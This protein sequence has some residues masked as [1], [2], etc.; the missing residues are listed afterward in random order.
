MTTSPP[1][2]TPTPTPTP[3]PPTRPTPLSA[4]RGPLVRFR[5][6]PFRTG[7]AEALVH[8]PDGLLICE[9]GRITAAGPYAALRDRLPPGTEPVHYP[10]HLITA[11]FVDAH[12]H[13][14]QL[15]A[16]A[17]FGAQLPDWLGHTYDT[18]KRFAD[19]THARRVA[20]AFCDELLRN[21]TTTALAF[22]SVHPGSA[23]A[24]F[25][26]AT[27]RDLRIAA[28]K[29]LMDRNA[30]DSLLDTAQRAYDESLDLIQ[31]WHGKGRNLYAV[32]PR[33]APTS[34]P[35]Q[36]EAARALRAARPDTLL[37]THISEHR[38]EIPWVRSLFPDRDGYLDV[39]D[40]YGLLGPRT[41]LA[42]GIHLTPSERDHCARTGTAVAHCPSSNL[43]LGSGLFPL[44]EAKEGDHPLTVALGTDIGAGTSFSLLQTM[45]DAHQVAKLRDHALDAVRAFYLATRGGA[46][47]LGLADTI[48]SLTPG[49]EADFAVLDPR[50]T[51]L[52]AD[53][54]AR[55]ETIEDLLFALA[56]LG[57]DRAVRATYTGGR[58]AHERDAAT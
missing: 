21:G 18:E 6:D 19:G 55:A 26:E 34:T 40:H 39:Y 3:I 12:T 28:G 48:G 43:F 2:P 35:A 14:A 23:D 15:E 50:A 1:T 57:D 11:G 7:T 33:F 38:D 52:L 13:Y 31:R 17:R 53:R 8:D 5:A 20:S 30:P 27:R 29:V 22:A 42:H 24:L 58:P 45:R 25:E 46:E 47:A 9:A 44:R 4:V 36:L 56:V 32:T 37:H 16:V 51:P 54:T 41:V 49:Q 10:G